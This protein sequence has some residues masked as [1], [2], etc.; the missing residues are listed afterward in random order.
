MAELAAS[1]VQ[2][3][4]LMLPHL[5]DMLAT[6]CSDVY[7]SRVS[8]TT[9]YA[10]VPEELKAAT[11]AYAADHG[12]TLANAVSDLLSRGM[13][14]ASCEAS[15]KALEARAKELQR[16]LDQVRPALDAVYER[17]PQILGKCRCGRDLTGEDFLIKGVCPGCKTGLTGALAGEAKDDGPTVN[18]ADLTPFLAGVGIALAVILIACSTGK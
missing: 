3:D 5:I 11:D 8:T 12:M 15:V 1:D 2:G 6:D 13:E 10:R 18:R 16:E 7:P 4:R 14:A 17:L 9:I